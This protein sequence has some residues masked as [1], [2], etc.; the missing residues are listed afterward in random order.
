[1][2]MSSQSIW[3]HINR[4]VIKSF[5]LNISL[6]PKV[7]AVQT[8]AM[9]SIRTRM[10]AA[11]ATISIQLSLK[12]R[13]VHAKA[14]VIWNL[15][16]HA[17]ILRLPGRASPV[18]RPHRRHHSRRPSIRETV[19]WMPPTALHPVKWT[20]NHLETMRPPFQCRWQQIKLSTM[21]WWTWQT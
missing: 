15:W 2:P 21:L 5:Q 14:N 9:N 6:T 3:C 8:K 18:R 17:N 1:M 12:N 7:T 10:R 19:K 4:T 16:M 20:M 13:H 11:V